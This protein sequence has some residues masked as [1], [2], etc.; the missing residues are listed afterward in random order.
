MTC[1]NG[2]NVDIPNIPHTIV[3]AFLRSFNLMPLRS[4]FLG[5]K[6]NQYLIKEKKQHLPKWEKQTTE[7]L[8][9][10]SVFKDL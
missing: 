3:R 2:E 5:E 7:A 1:M 9:E 10:A 8:L 6:L 4:P